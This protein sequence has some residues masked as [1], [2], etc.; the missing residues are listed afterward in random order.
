VAVKLVC[1]GLFVSSVPYKFCLGCLKY[2]VGFFG[3]F[4]T[5]SVFFFFLAVI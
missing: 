4:E 3:I 2:C 5:G 1:G